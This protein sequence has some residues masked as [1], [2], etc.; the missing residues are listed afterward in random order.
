VVYAYGAECPKGP[1]ARLH[2]RVRCAPDDVAAHD[3]AA[4][5]AR[6]G[7]NDD[8]DDDDVDGD[9]TVDIARERTTGECAGWMRVRGR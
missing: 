9:T 1:I 6:H 5:T 2:P 4:R 3:V 7:A 8:D